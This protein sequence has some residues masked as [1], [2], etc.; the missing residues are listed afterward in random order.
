MDD[1]QRKGRIQ[2]LEPYMAT[3][4]DSPSILL[5]YKLNPT[6]LFQL[7]QHVVVIAE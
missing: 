5:T 3:I 1:L 4:Q 7:S 6:Y 2:N